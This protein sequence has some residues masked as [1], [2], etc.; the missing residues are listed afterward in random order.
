[1]YDASDGSGKVEHA[2]SLFVVERPVN[3]R[4]GG[5]KLLIKFNRKV[6]L[7][8]EERINTADSND[9]LAN[10]ESILEQ[11]TQ[12]LSQ[13]VVT[14]DQHGQQIE[15]LKDIMLRLDV[16]GQHVKADI[17]SLKDDVGEIRQMLFQ[18]VESINERIDNLSSGVNTRIEGV[19]ASVIQNTES[20]NTR[21]DNLAGGM[22]SRIDGVSARIDRLYRVLLAML[23][24]TIAMWGSLFIAIFKL[25]K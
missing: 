17:D 20:V 7:M 8:G 24:A 2:A 13:I 10:I 3:E 18:H 25:L 22:N 14:V 11:N 9:S 1:M 21:I 12:Q 16:N 19:N 5:L 15:S 6:V 23:G 4:A